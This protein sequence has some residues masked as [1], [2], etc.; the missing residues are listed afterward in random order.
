MFSLKD[1]VLRLADTQ[2]PAAAAAFSQAAHQS[3]HL[4]IQ[5]HQ[6]SPSTLSESFTNKKVEQQFWWSSVT[7]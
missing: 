1:V 3:N 2:Q 5:S 6:T 4:P 7:L